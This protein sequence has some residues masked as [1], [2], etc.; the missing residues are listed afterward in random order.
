M[1]VDEFIN[2]IEEEFEIKERGK[3]RP[4][5]V[6]REDFEWNSVNALIMISLMNVE[7]DVELTADDLNKAITI[8]DLYNI[9]KG[10][11]K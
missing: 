5:S 2:K 8:R 6:I 11:L 3:L 1:N 4:D 9:V 7:Y 10:K